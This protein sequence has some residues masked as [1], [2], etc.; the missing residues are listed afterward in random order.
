MD[1]VRARP[2]IGEEV[3]AVLSVNVRVNDSC[4]RHPANRLRTFGNRNVFAA[5]STSSSQISHLAAIEPGS[6][7]PKLYSMPSTPQLSVIWLIL[8]P[9]GET[10]A[11]PPELPGVSL[12]S[13]QP[14][15][16]TSINR[17]SAGGQVGELVVA[18][19]VGRG[20]LA[21]VVAVAVDQLQHVRRRCLLRPGR[22][23]LPSSSRS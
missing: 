4:R 3:F 7:S 18:I 2:Q 9:G 1:A 12:P 10:S 19:G 20:P 22:S 6:N 8:S 21:G 5:R 16:C 15:G 13:S 11:T 17:V 23:K 14:A